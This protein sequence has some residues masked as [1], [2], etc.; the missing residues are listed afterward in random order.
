MISDKINIYKNQILVFFIIFS[1]YISRIFNKIFPANYQQDDV[2]ELRVVFYDDILCAIRYGGDNH[3]LLALITW[4]ASKI[5]VSPEYVISFFI[6]ST[7][8]VSYFLMF[9]IL[10]ESYPIYISILGLVIILFSPVIL[11]YSISLKQYI[12]ELFACLYSFRFVQ[13]YLNNKIKKGH[14]SRYILFSS[15][16]VLISF[17]NIL[18]FAMTVFFI[19]FHDKKLKFKQIAIPLFLLLPFS[20]MFIDKLQR[21]S[22]GGYWDS[23]FLSTNISSLNQLIQNIYFLITLFVKSLFIENVLFV[24]LFLFFVSLIIPFITKNKITLYAFIGII[25][26]FF[27]SA[28]RLY[29]L[30]AG[31]T[32]IVFL[33]YFVYLIAAFFNWLSV[34]TKLNYNFLIILISV[35]YILNGYLNSNVYYKDENVAPLIEIVEEEYNSQE[36]LIVVEK[37]QYSSIL[38]YSKNL[39]NNTTVEDLNKCLKTLPNI[40]N[41]YVSHENNLFQN[42]SSVPIKN[43][44]SSLFSDLNNKHVYLVGIELDGTVGNFRDTIKELEENLFYKKT[45]K[46]FNSGLTIG[47][48]VKNG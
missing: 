42:Y 24:A 37:E 10:D 40:T 8:I 2:S 23:F 19:L 39:V 6:V 1:V 48:F 43:L 20:T 45:L 16:L 25:I 3:P 4:I 26:L 34:K 21:V 17:V 18:P 11:T 46:K 44:K 35:L 12:F 13:L 9:K 41:L 28:L 38:Y 30:G 14:Y 47:Y 22:S 27:I 7:T 36:T 31:R 33:P 32:D 15:V 29:P 5:F